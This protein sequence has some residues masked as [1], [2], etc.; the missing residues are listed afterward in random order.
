MLFLTKTITKNCCFVSRSPITP[1][2]LCE[3]LLYD[4]HYGQ[5]DDKTNDFEFLDVLWQNP[6]QEPKKTSEIHASRQQRRTRA[7][8][9]AMTRAANAGVPAAIRSHTQ[10]TAL[11]TAR[12][13][14]SFVIKCEA[15]ASTRDSRMPESAEVGSSI[16]KERLARV[17]VALSLCQGIERLKRNCVRLL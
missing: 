6:Y 13:D 10:L 9:R 5:N 4:Y 15:D 16:I 14:L 3:S 1:Q 17:V 12:S 2:I 11:V 7:L 8:K